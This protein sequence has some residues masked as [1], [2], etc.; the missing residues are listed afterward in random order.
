MEAIALACRHGRLD[1]HITRVIADRSD[2]AGL[3]VAERMGIACATFDRQRYGDREQHEQ[4]V[5]GEIGRSEAQLVVLAGYMRILSAAF[6]DALRG[7]LL[8]IH[9]S[10]LPAYKGLHTHRRVIEARDREHGASVHFVTAEL[11]GGPVICRA[12]VPVDPA[13]TEQQLAAR[14]LAREHALYPF[15]IGLIASQRVKLSGSQVWFD[16]GALGAPLDLDDFVPA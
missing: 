4:A 3:A 12:R 13:D 9:P 5:L 8:N 7:Q 15:A 2:A 1:A 10:L 16:D 6:V 11:D 14:V